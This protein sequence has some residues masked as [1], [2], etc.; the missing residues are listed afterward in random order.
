MD[1]LLAKARGSAEQAERKTLY[2]RAGKTIWDDAV[3]IFPATIT[4]A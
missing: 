2:A 3:G 1:E 4:T